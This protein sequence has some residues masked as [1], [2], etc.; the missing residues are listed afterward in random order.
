[1]VDDRDRILRAE[2]RS[3]VHREKLFHRAVHVFVFNSAGQI[4]LQKRSMAKD[5]APGR[6]AS[7]C[8]GHVDSGEDYDEAVRR[9]LI[10]EIGLR[11]PAGLER[12]FKDTPRPETGYEFTWTYRCFSEGPFTLD[13]DEISD[14][15]W[16]DLADLDGWMERTR[17][18]FAASFVFQWKQYLRKF[19]SRD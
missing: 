16:I 18:D 5:T 13:P 7:S 19:H 14:G 2:H 11:E 12:L 3:V 15:R 17:D 9:E 6:W 1:M 4:F 8:S 10:E